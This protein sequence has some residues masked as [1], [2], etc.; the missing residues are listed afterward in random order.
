MFIFKESLIIMD[1]SLEA[2]LEAWSPQVTDFQA[3]WL[4]C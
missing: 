3:V 2:H 4:Y 1:N